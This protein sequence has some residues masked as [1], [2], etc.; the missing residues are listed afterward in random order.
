MRG[1]VNSVAIIGMGLIGGSLARAL[2]QHGC[3]VFGYDSCDATTALARA[4]GVR[5]LASPAEAPQRADAGVIALPDSQVEPILA[6]LRDAPEGCAITET[7]S[8]KGSVAAAA[9][10]IWPQG[11]PWLVLS[12][13]LAGREHS[14][15]A[16][17]SAELFSGVVVLLSALPYSCAEAVQRIEQLWTLVGGAPQPMPVDTHDGI[18]AMTSH[19]PHIL[20]FNL[21]SVLVE[22]LGEVGFDYTGGG[23]RDFSRIA[24]S[25]AEM[26]TDIAMSNSAHI[27]AAVRA[28]G[29]GLEQLAQR[30]E[31]R[32]RDWVHQLFAGAARARDR[33][34]G[35]P[36]P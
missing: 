15:Y 7:G 29:V 6:Q 13:P 32:E 4:D 27:A 31:A 14:G 17:A 35:E 36:G 20:A 9:Q 21:V 33:H 10:R 28:Y 34:Y 30:I 25:S 12:H 24:S 19:L 5:I 11:N 1:S 18:L 23:F 3:E 16:A 22:Q 2:Q 26:W 8:T